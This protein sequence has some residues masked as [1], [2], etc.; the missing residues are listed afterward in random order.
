MKNSNK[1]DKFVEA[2]KKDILATYKF[3][4]NR[5]MWSKFHYEQ[6]SKMIEDCK[7]A[8][9]LHLA[10]DSIVSGAMYEMESPKHEAMEARTEKMEEM[11]EDMVESRFY[12]SHFAMGPMELS[13]GPKPK[14][15]GMMLKKKK[16]K[17]KKAGK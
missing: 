6:W 4:Y 16:M 17:A 10:W 7:D 2:N 14:K 3:L 9:T 15:L 11:V 12:M 8:E 13:S 1:N 5:G